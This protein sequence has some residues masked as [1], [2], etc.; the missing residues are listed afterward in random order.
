LDSGGCG[1]G[2][3]F[4][5]SDWLECKYDKGCT[6]VMNQC[7]GFE[8]GGVWTKVSD[9]A[10]GKKGACP[11]GTGRAGDELACSTANAPGGKG[12]SG[13]IVAALVIGAV[14]VV[15]ALVYVSNRSPPK[16]EEQ[17]MQYQLEK[18]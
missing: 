3:S 11:P 18:R 5:S 6:K 2:D 4:D 15:G 1:K 13:V 9:L 14:V 10:A 16:Q 17:D 12:L 8:T 7:G